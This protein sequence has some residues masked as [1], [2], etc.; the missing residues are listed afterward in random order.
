M[1]SAPVARWFFAL[2][3]TVVT[4]GLVLQ[5]G[6]SIASD[7]GAE[8]FASTPDRIVNFFSFFTVLSNVAVAATC[9]LLAVDPDRPSA[10]FRVL[11]LDAVVAIT[12]TGVVFHLTLAQLQEL[13]GWSAAA[14]AILHTASPILGLGGWLWFGPR[15][16][17]GTRTVVWSVAAPV[18]W[19]VYTLARGEF[20]DDRFGRA[21]FPYPFMDV[22]EHGY[23]VVLRNV[24]LVAVLF[25]AL[26][27]AARALDRRLGGVRP[28]A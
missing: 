14:D 1:R 16:G 24:T 19:I 17:I 2:T 22:E 20:V 3:A 12:V 9:A 6:L 27:F 10:V 13:T 28:R 25:L 26:A 18:G 8:R 11:R 5:L 7:T 21:Y 23:P 15:G 4:F